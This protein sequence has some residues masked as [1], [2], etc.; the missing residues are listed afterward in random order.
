MLPDI[1]TKTFSPDKYL[2]DNYPATNDCVILDKQLGDL[3]K[4]LEKITKMQPT[5]RNAFERLKQIAIIKSTKTKISLLLK[6]RENQSTLKD[7]RNQITATNLPITSTK[8]LTVQN[9]T[10][11]TS[12][13]NSNSSSIT[14]GIV[15]MNSNLAE[16]E[17]QAET[18]IISDSK[19]KQYVLLG[20]G[21][22]VLI[23]V[24]Y[25]IIKNRK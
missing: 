3:S 15:G 24:L 8:D 25:I 2:L 5:S 21:G 11:N 13:P 18:R 19:Q 6:T 14:P 7:C 23:G 1:I 10:P 17:N 20:V 22:L 16:M 12:I 4:D 9:A